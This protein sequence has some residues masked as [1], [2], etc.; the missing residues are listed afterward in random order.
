[1][2]GSKQF[3]KSETKLEQLF[4]PEIIHQMC[5]IYIYGLFVMKIC[6]FYAINYCYVSIGALSKLIIVKRFFIGN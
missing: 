2:F 4:Q 3:F 5:T 1:M 6:L